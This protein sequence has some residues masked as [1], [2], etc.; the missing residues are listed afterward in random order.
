MDTQMP[1]LSGARLVEQL[2]ARTKASIYA[3]SGGDV[4]E[5]V[6]KSVDGHLSK[7]FG[8]QA[9]QQLMA[10]HHPQPAAE[11]EDDT[12]VIKSETL[13]QL[14]A[15]MPEPAVR[16]IYAAVVDDLDK[17]VT[18]LQRAL[19][20]RDKKEI[21]RIGHSIKGGCGMAGALQAARIGARLEARGDELD[22]V[23][24]LLLELKAAGRNLRRMLEAE[25]SA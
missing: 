12:P 22:N 1:G 5:E 14:R 6:R 20:E 18:A 21:R 17:R 15:M 8:P 16:Q 19:G 24:A 3:M 9:L 4:P 23:P 2:R 13:A 10:Q 25:F 7:P 11:P